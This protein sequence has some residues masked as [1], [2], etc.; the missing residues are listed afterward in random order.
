MYAWHNVSWWGIT[1]INALYKVDTEIISA[2]C[3]KI[4]AHGIFY[5]VGHNNKKYHRNKGT[6][7]NKE[8]RPQKFPLAVVNG[9]KQHRRY[10]EIPNVIGDSEP[11]AKGNFIVQGAVYHNHGHVHKGNAH[12]LVNHRLY[13]PK[14]QNKGIFMPHYPI[15][16]PHNNLFYKAKSLFHYSAPLSL[17]R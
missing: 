5:A 4:G 12:K 17:K 6:A 11:F 7:D 1:C 2:Q 3:F 15:N 16:L 13:R 9:V 8:R 10:I 14:Q